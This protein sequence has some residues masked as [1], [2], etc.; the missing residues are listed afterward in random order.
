M[1]E[2]TTVPGSVWDA[3]W[4]LIASFGLCGSCHFSPVRDGDF[5]DE[6]WRCPRCGFLSSGDPEAWGP[7]TR[8]YD[9][10]GAEEPRFVETDIP[11]E[12]D[13]L[14]EDLEP[15]FPIFDHEI[16]R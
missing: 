14:D 12:D 13:L 5:T 4:E 8:N 1:D 9:P 6:P 7:V 3:I 2:E 11:D 16:T 15:D 10:V